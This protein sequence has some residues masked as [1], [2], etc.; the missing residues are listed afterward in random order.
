[1]I[2]PH[3]STLKIYIALNVHI[4]TR[5]ILAWQVYDS[6]TGNQIQKQTTEVNGG[7]KK[8]QTLGDGSPLLRLN[9]VASQ[10]ALNVYSLSA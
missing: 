4:Q 9:W 10:A 5:K 7:S 1:M 6:K 8:T 3:Y 2:R